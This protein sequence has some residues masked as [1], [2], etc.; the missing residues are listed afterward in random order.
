MDLEVFNQWNQTARTMTINQA[1]ELF[2]Q[3]SRGGISLVNSDTNAGYVN[4]TAIYQQIA[5]LV[6]TRDMEA[7]TN[8]TEK[9]LEQTK[10]GSVKVGGLVGPVTITNSHYTTMLKN[11]EEAGSVIGQQT[12]LSQ[13]QWMLNTGITSLATC[14]S[15]EGATITHDGTAATAT[16]SGLGHAAAKFGDQAGR[17]TVWVMHSKVYFD[18]Y[19]ANLANANQLFAINNVVLVQDPFGR[20]IIVTDSPSLVETD[21]V[22]VGVDKYTTIGLTAGG[23]YL[24]ANNDYEEKIL[25]VLGKENIKTIRQAEYSVNFGVKGYRWGASINSPLDAELGTNTNWTKATNVDHKDLA[26]VVLE[27]R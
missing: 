27:S 16:L 26:G 21:G 4:E 14:L 12:A 5:G 3:V 24:E 25:P 23:L 19:Q 13:L 11:P 1:V 22:S 7:D 8:A 20:P 18:L 9:A 17:V 6:R 2:N 10:E 15:K